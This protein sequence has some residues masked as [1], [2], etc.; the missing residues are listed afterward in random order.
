MML[1]PQVLWAITQS[2]VQSATD[3]E[4]SLDPNLVGKL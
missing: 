1:V 4:A 3:L 2:A